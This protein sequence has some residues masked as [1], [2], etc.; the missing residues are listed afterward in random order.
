MLDA[1]EAHRTRRRLGRLMR[2]IDLLYQEICELERELP[3][4]SQP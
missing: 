2:Q 1:T 3:H 4:E